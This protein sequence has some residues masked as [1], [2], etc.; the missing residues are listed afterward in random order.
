METMNKFVVAYY[1]E[2]YDMT[3]APV[4]AAEYTWAIAIIV[5]GLAALWQA[6]V[7]VSKF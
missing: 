3:N 4:V 1:G 5:I 6:R 7:F 2:G